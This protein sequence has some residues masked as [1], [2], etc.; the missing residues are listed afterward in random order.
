MAHHRAVLPLL[1]GATLAL[2][3]ATHAGARQA[4]PLDTLTA[5]ALLEEASE[6]LREAPALRRDRRF[7]ERLARLRESWGLDGEAARA[8]LAPTVDPLGRLL[9][10]GRVDEALAGVRDGRDVRPDSFTL[11]R[12]L[13]ALVAEGREEEAV[14]WADS[15]N[16][17]SMATLLVLREGAGTAPER[18]ARVRSLL[19]EGAVARF[20]RLQVLQQIVTSMA[21]YDGLAGSL[22]DQARPRPPRRKNR[23]RTRDL[24]RLPL[25]GYLGNLVPDVHPTP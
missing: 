11:N 17:T 22:N 1:L 21:S 20:Q 23:R 5:R 2:G 14:R 10:E 7:V 15:L 6:A 25:T 19:D 3:Q 18:V 16:A 8:L 4:A 12:L 24:H 13:R 9:A